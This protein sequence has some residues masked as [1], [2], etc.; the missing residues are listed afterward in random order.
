MPFPPFRSPA[1]THM[2]ARIPTHARAHRPHTRSVGTVAPPTVRFTE[3]SR[4]VFPGTPPG[5][6]CA[7][8]TRIGV[9]GRSRPGARRARIATVEGAARSRETGIRKQASA[10]GDP[11]QAH[12]FI[13]EVQ[14]PVGH[15]RTLRAARRGG[16]ARRSVPPCHRRGPAR[17]GVAV[18][19][20]GSAMRRGVPRSAD[21]GGGQPR[22]VRAGPAR[23]TGVIQPEAGGG[24]RHRRAQPGMPFSHARHRL[25]TL[26]LTVPQLAPVQ[27]GRRQSW[28][29]SVLFIGCRRRAAPVRYDRRRGGQGG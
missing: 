2:H 24:L 10:I 9:A 17:R 28:Q 29:Q 16:P 18:P 1:R 12:T 11:R 22:R 21:D 23:A 7:G 20:G 27:D 8:T 5:G 26:A 4:T 15:H 14:R 25:Q 3:P 6:G 13:Q 19:C